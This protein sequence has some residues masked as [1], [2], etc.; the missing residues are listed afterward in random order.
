MPTSGKAQ[1]ELETAAGKES[2]ELRDKK[3]CFIEEQHKNER[4]LGEKEASLSLLQTL[5]YESLEQAQTARSDNQK[6]IDEI[7]EAIETAR[8]NKADA[9]TNWPESIPQSRN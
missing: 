6:M 3:D 4:S 2:T 1:K 8:R 9:E 5:P 7:A